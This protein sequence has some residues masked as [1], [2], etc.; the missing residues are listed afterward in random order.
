L[1]GKGVPPKPLFEEER[2]SS[3]DTRKK[4]ILKFY[5]S[6]NAAMAAKAVG[7]SQPTV[8]ERWVMKYQQAV[9]ER[10]KSDTAEGNKDNGDK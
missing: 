3:T 1:S 10:D 6:G 7:L 8:V 4:A 2:D 5:E 9:D